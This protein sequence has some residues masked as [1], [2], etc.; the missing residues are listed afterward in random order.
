MSWVMDAT[1]HFPNGLFGI[2]VPVEKRSMVCRR[3]A[4]ANVHKSRGIAS[5]LRAL[6]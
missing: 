1:T 3:R 4:F 2:D 5:Q 6:D